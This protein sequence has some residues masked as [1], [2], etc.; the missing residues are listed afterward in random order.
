[1]RGAV[2]G[3]GTGISAGG[4]LVSGAA[5]PVGAG[6]AAAEEQDLTVSWS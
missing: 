5:W 1:M 3:G 2:E 4:G 6:E